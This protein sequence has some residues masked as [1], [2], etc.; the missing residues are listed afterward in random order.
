MRYEYPHLQCL[1]MYLRPSYGRRKLNM[2][3]R[4][5]RDN[6][7]RSFRD[8]PWCEYFRHR[9]TVVSS[10]RESTKTWDEARCRI[11][12]T[13]REGKSSHGATALA[14][15]RKAPPSPIN[16]ASIL[17]LKYIL[18]APSAFL[19]RST[20]TRRIRERYVEVNRSSQCQI[21]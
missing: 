16:S 8:Q 20:C 13:E 14:Q 6:A 4:E 5:M 15:V 7:A 3:S 2:I 21:G 10:E 19:S 12:V 1:Q 11:C 9:R 17:S 18:L